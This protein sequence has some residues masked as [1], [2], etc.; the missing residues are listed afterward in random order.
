M[1]GKTKNMI[2]SDNKEGE[3]ERSY[4]KVGRPETSNLAPSPVKDGEPAHKE[5][6]EGKRKKVIISD[7]TQGEGEQRTQAKV[8]RFRTSEVEPLEK[9]SDLPQSIPTT[10][11]ET[12]PENDEESFHKECL[13]TMSTQDIQQ[14]VK[15]IETKEPQNRDQITSELAPTPDKDDSKVQE[16]GVKGNI[17]LS[18][19]GSDVVARVPPCLIKHV[20]V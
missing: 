16:E 18:L 20:I 2:I 8:G 14:K 11:E 1:R 15:E 7:N 9:E 13:K 6:M 12:E 19:V 5:C 10:E 4:A 3:A 17:K